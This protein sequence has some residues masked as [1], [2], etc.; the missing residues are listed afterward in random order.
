MKILVTGANGYMGT[1]IVRQLLDD[2]MTVIAA[3]LDTARVDA[4]AE[5]INAS[6]FEL[7]D[8]FSALQQPDV[9]LHLAWRDGFRHNAESHINDFPLHYAFLKKMAQG[10]VKR[11][12]V[13]GTMHEI[14]WYE[15]EISE[16]TPEHPLS[17]YGIS[18]VA[19]HR[20]LELIAKEHKVSLQWMRGFYI[21]GNARYGNSIFSKLI[22]AEEEGKNEFPFTMG[23]NKYDF[24]DYEE[25]CLQVAAVAEQDEVC[26][27]IN[28]CSGVAVAL[29]DRVN[30]FIQENNLN[31]ELKYGVFPERP[32][33]SKEVWG[34]ATKIRKIMGRRT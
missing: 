10:G 32:Y 22:Q 11:I 30:R 1:G 29:R 26:G 8:P 15:G 20:S 28:C 7:E 14:G 23:T 21:V 13:M 9:L 18:K 31:I 19:L 17:L 3:D 24:L 27:V 4:R 16:N 25:F 33:D 34:D 12:A 5:R 2:G 6:I